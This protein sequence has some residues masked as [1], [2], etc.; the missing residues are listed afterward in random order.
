M[1][2]SGYMCEEHINGKKNVLIPLLVDDP[3]W[4]VAANVTAES[5]IVLI[6]LLVDDPLWVFVLKL[7]AI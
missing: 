4:A 6:P 3:L 5:A 1:T 2:R 7:Q